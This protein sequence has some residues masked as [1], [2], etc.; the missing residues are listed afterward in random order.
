MKRLKQKEE[1]KVV[2]NPVETVDEVVDEPE[3]E[4]EAY[5][6]LL[7]AYYVMRGSLN[8]NELALFSDIVVKDVEA[9]KYVLE[10]MYQ[11]SIEQLIQIR[12]GI[13]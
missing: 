9:S 6:Q 8:V 7:E 12:K 13:A 5:D 3:S 4:S 2:D 11:M 10:K 1:V